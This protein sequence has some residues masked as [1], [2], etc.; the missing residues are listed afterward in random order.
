MEAGQRISVPRKQ[1]VVPPVPVPQAFGRIQVLSQEDNWLQ[2][3][4]S[5]RKFAQSLCQLGTSFQLSL[6]VCFVAATTGAADGDAVSHRAALHPL[7][8]AQSE[9]KTVHLQ[10]RERDAPAS[11]RSECSQAVLLIWRL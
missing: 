8:E 5:L 6:S 1:D 11:M 9:A 4:W 7:R 2:L 3:R 10:E